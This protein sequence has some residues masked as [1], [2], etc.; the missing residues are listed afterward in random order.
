MASRALRLGFPSLLAIIAACSGDRTEEQLGVSLEALSTNGR[1]LSFEG[2]IGGSG[3]GLDWKAAVGT[4]TSSTTANHLT[5]AMAL[6]ANWNP[7]ATS[8]PLSALGPLSGPPKIDVRF[9][10]GYANQGS[11]WGQAALYITCASAN[12]FNH[13]V[14]PAQLL[15]PTGT[16][17]T[18]TL[19]TLPSNVA[20]ALSNQNGCTVKGRAESQQQRDPPRPRRPPHLR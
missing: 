19:G 4:A 1:I 13:Y 2:G 10:T 7:S 8:A 5:K 6:G 15:G 16:Y 20:S 3:T 14:S 9:P 17:K 12:I 18:Y 11:Y